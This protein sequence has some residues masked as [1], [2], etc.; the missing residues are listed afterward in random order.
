MNGFCSESHSGDDDFNTNELIMHHIKDSHDWNLFSY[1]KNG[2]KHQVAIP[3]PIVLIYDGKFDVFMSS[4]FNHGNAVVTKG[5]R[6][7]IMHHE[8]IY[9]ANDAGA[10][11]FEKSDNGK[12]DKILN[13]KPYDF[14]ITRNV[15]ALFL[16][17]GILIWL[18]VGVAKSYKKRPGRPAGIQAFLEPLILFV[19]DDIVLPNIGHRKYEKF[20]PYLLTVFFFIL[21]SNVLGLIPFF[22]GGSNVTGNIAV[23]FILALITLILTNI[24]GNRSYWKHIFAAPGVPVWLYIV[25]IPVE[26]IGIISKP[27][28]LMIRLFANITAGHIVVLSLV[29]LIFIFKTL[30]IS[31]VAVIFAVFMDVLELLVAFLQAYI[32]TIL[33][34]LFI[35]MAV[36]EEHH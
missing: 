4:E 34:A 23:T 35:G 12:E 11:D 22:P 7:Y 20:L 18:F 15:A 30:W 13:N 1:S 5:D 31:P 2:E 36:Q 32:F 28:A 17:I 6:N 3:L 14:S 8:K 24:N 10:L 33:S 16:T 29:S 9:L 21:F 25:I 27:F 19:R 26:L